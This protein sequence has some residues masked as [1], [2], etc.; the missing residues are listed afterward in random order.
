MKLRH[1]TTGAMALILISACSD[2]TGVTE[3]DLAGTWTASSMVFTSVENHELTADVI[4]DGASLVLTLG[5]DGTFS[6]VLNF[7]GEPVEDDTGT[8][9]VTGSTL[10]FSDSVES[11]TDTFTIARDGDTMTLTLS[12]EVFDFVDGVEEA[13]TLVI[14]LTR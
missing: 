11:T 10:V 13:A 9:T 12:D 7:P 3:D 8:Y 5:A 2:A 4:A 1:L 14:T 6:V